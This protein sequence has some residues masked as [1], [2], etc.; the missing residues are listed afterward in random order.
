MR[1]AEQLRPGLYEDLTTEQL[2]RALES[3]Q[4]DL[5]ERRLLD[6]GDADVVIARYVGQ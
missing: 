1:E 2:E 4:T 5:I 6:P 3:I